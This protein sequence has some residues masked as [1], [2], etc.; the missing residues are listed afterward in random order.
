MIFRDANGKLKEIRRYDF[1]NELQYYNAI[2][3]LK[4]ETQNIY[5]K[6]QNSTYKTEDSS[7]DLMIHSNKNNSDKTWIDRK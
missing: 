7:I 2:I 3:K 1:T 6:M 5:E 4:Q